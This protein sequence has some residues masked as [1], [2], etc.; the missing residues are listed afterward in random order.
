LNT[1]WI[2]CNSG[3]GFGLALFFSGGAMIQA[4][5]PAD[6]VVHRLCTEIARKCTAIIQPLL[7]QEEVGECLREF[8]L[9]AREVIEKP[10]RHEREV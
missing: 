5:V 6:P 4:N 1:N 7:R 3:R 8:Y 2:K 10:P 9:A